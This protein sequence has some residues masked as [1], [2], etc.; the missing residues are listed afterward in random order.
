MKDFKARVWD[1][2]CK[3]YPKNYKLYFNGAVSI[4][5]TWASNDSI[6][7]LYLGIKDKN[8]VEIYAGD[9]VKFHYFTE[10]LGEDLGVV[11][12][13]KELIGHIVFQGLGLWFASDTE[14]NSGYLIWFNGIHEESF[15][16]IGNIHENPELLK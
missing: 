12:G 13:E 1:K 10:E 5:D 16:I 7:E 14:E 11:E 8:A 4:E 9:I 2:V 6:I 15:E 3:C